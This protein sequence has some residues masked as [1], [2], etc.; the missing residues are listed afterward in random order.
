M[1][2]TPDWKAKCEELVERR[3]GPLRICDGV[4]IR[5]SRHQITADELY[6]LVLAAQRDVLEQAAEWIATSANGNLEDNNHAATIRLMSASLA[7]T[8]NNE[9]G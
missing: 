4:Q 6:A 8:P 7:P 5:A 9:H 3:V 2:D 1:I